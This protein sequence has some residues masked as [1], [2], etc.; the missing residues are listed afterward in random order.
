MNAIEEI[1]TAKQV[2][3]HTFYNDINKTM[4]YLTI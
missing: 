2:N 4:H 1:E 3:P